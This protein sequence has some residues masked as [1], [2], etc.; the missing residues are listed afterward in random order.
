LP[1]PIVARSIAEGKLL[2]VLE[3]FA[4]LAPGVFLFHP[5]RHQVMPKLRAFSE[6]VKARVG[7]RASKF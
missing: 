7:S 6:H 3:R 2:R 5:G 4:P 1:E